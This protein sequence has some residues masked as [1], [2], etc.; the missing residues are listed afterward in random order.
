MDRVAEWV[1]FAPMLAAATAVM[2]WMAGAI[3]YDVGGGRRWGH[4]ATAV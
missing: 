1:V 4:L 3:Y 2:L